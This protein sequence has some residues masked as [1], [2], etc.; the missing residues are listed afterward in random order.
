MDMKSK[1]FSKVPDFPDI[2]K[3]IPIYGQNPSLEG[4]ARLEGRFALF[5]YAKKNF[6][7]KNIFLNNDDNPE[8]ISR[9]IAIWHMSKAKRLS[10]EEVLNKFDIYITPAGDGCHGEIWVREKKRQRCA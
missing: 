6:P 5:A 4:F 3:I 2:E 9:R 1:I 8:M 10:F 7:P